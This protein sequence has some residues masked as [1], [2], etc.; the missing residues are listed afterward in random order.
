MVKIMNMVKKNF[1]IILV[2]LLVIALIT[3]Y[4]ISDAKALPNEK[5][6]NMLFTTISVDEYL[7]LLKSDEMSIVYLGRPNCPYSQNATKTLNEIVE[8]YDITIHYLN[9]N[10]FTSSETKSKFEN[11]HEKFKEGKWAVPT[12][13]IVQNNDIVEEIV[14]YSPDNSTK[15]K[16]L[17]LFQENKFIDKIE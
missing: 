6:N 8:K 11:S 2:G 3:A 16:Y 4:F 17:K 13:M 7:E 5:K 1:N 14:G 10:S 12:V 15:N 9:T